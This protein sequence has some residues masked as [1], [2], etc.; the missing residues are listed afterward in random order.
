MT[1]REMADSIKRQ[2]QIVRMLE[3]ANKIAADVVAKEKRTGV[4]PQSVR[5]WFPQAKTMLILF[6]KRRN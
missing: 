2:A 1:A 5:V 4:R 6:P 3:D